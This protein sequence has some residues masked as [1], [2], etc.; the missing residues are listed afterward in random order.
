VWGYGK[1]SPVLQKWLRTTR[2]TASW[3]PRAKQWANQR[4]EQ[5]WSP[6]ISYTIASAWEHSSIHKQYNNLMHSPQY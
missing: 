2:I 4:L 5:L 3:D 6:Y 1:T